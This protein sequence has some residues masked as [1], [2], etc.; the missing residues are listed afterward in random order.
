MKNFKVQIGFYTDSNKRIKFR[1]SIELNDSTMEQVF[2]D[3]MDL[4]LNKNIKPDQV[5]QLSINQ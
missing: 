2:N 4:Y 5:K 3:F 1:H